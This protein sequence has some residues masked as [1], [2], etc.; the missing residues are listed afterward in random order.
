MDAGLTDEELDPDLVG[1]W[2]A[3]SGALTPAAGGESVDVITD[4]GSFLSLRFDGDGAFMLTI[5][6]PGQEDPFQE[7]A[8]WFTSGSELMLLYPGEDAPDTVTY[9]VSGGDLTIEVAGDEYDFDGD[10]TADAA[11]G[12]Y[13][14]VSID[15][16]P[17][18]LLTAAW[19]AS[20]FVYTPVGGGT[21]R[22]LV[23]DGW[24]LELS[25]QDGGGFHFMRMNPDDPDAQ[26]QE[27]MGGYVAV[28]GL[29]WMMAEGG[30]VAAP[31]MFLAAYTTDGE[32]L[33]LSSDHAGWDFDGDHVV[34][35]A[36]LQAQLGAH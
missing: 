9:Q 11:H 22:E 2:I 32:T 30:S 6:E 31:A 7:S 13:T 33:T 27:I 5:H 35:P 14:L 12:T 34:E 4:A 8:T 19:G 17:D 16:T 24:S 28:Q 29:V 36:T 26:Q 3:V 15:E 21:A 18:P 1:E 25:F 23:G 10:G 20:S